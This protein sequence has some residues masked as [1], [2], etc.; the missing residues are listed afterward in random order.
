[1]LNF[2]TESTRDFTETETVGG[3]TNGSRS[4]EFDAIFE[5]AYEELNAQGVNV[6]ANVNQ[7]LDRNGKNKLAAYKERLLGQLALE[8]EAMNGDVETYG[9]HVNLY[10]Q[11]SGLFDNCVDDF[12]KESTAVGNLLPIKSIDFPLLIKQ[13][14]SLASKDIIQTEVTRSPLIKKH[15]EQQW[16][17]SNQDKSKRWKYPQCFFDDSFKEV[18]QEGKGLP[19]KNT[20]VALPQM[21]YDVIGNLTDAEDPKREKFTFDIQII[22][23]QLT[24]PGKADPVDY[25]FKRPMRINLSTNQWLGGEIETTVTLDDGSK[26]TVKDIVTGTV[27]FISYT[28]SLNSVAGLVSGVVFAGHLSN[29]KNERSVSF[30]YTREEI[31]WKIEDGARANVSFS[32]EELEDAKALLDLDLYKKTYNHM[33]DYLTQQE[34]SGIIAWLDEQFELYKGVEV[35]DADALGWTGFVTEDEFDFDSTTITTALPCEYISKMLKFKI[36]GLIVDMADKAKMEGMTFVI[37][38]NPRY[39]RFLSP[40]INWITK[41]GSTSNGVKLDYGYGVMTSGDIK[42]QV[43]STKK[44]NAKYD[45]G[46]MA[47][48]GLR[49]IPFPISENLFT[50]KHYKHTSHVLTA[51]NS[52]YRDPNL[53]GGSMTNLMGVS[54]YK[55]VSIQGIQTEVKFT[56][57]EKYIKMI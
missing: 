7:L 26:K 47:H 11:V 51:Q 1:M 25:V 43:V 3:F 53:P 9:T 49:I 39:I 40:E 50:F 32:L 19:I 27:D 45:K 20:L 10:D 12:M 37:Y 55:T 57:A 42:V 41:P 48:K 21:D 14:L 56:S 36:D 2:L 28:V 13:H 23:A 5:S 30:D 31:E 18:Y 38:G 29:D 8:S 44:V 33:A 17:V 6:M 24:I 46:A 35:S 4:Q 52:A 34:D 15:I 54:R 22:K 16:V